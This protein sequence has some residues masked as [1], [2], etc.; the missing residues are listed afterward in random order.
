[1]STSANVGDFPAFL[2]HLRVLLDPKNLPQ[3]LPQHDEPSSKYGCFINFSVDPEILQHVEDEVGTISEQFKRVFG[4]ATRSTGNGLLKL[5]QRG[6]A[7]SAVVD[8]L[9]FYHK[10]HPRDEVLMKWGYDIGAAAEH[11][12]AVHGMKVRVQHSNHDY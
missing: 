8:V 7:L 3:Q 4:W 9:G 10:K 12:Y 6:K 5:E 1:M 11:V 2:S